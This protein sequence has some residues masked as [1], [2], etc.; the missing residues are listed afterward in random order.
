MHWLAVGGIVVLAVLSNLTALARLYRL[1]RTLA[2][3]PAGLRE[4]DAH[5]RFLHASAA[6]LA[7]AA[8]FALVVFLVERGGLTPTLATAIGA[9]F[10]A[11]VN[12]GFNRIVTFH[13]T[14]Q[15]SS[16]V[17]RYGVVSASSAMLNSGGVFLVVLL[18]LLSYRVGWWIVRL[19]VY[20]TWNFPLHRDYV[21]A[22][23]EGAASSGGL[24]DVELR[25]ER[26]RAGRG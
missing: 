5:T 19:F 11:A 4:V 13:S 1:I 21:F 14:R 24:L 10:G 2:P 18:D 17:L 12:L 16:Q 8:D 6:V 7:T 15:V 23:S 22:R 20:L 26:W 25:E 9:L 3:E